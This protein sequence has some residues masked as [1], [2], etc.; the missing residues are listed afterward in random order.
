MALPW[1]A[2]GREPAKKYESVEWSKEDCPVVEKMGC[3]LLKERDYR[4]GGVR[5]A[6]EHSDKRIRRG[7]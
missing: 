3:G 6:A 5:A 7:D 2:S 1:A 4:S